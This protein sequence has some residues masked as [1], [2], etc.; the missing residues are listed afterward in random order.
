MMC[1]KRQQ[2][3]N[4]KSDIIKTGDVLENVSCFYDVLKYIVSRSYSTV[5]VSV[6]VRAVLSL[7][8]TL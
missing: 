1:L 4:M 6:L 2:S 7:E 8:E 3:R 5:T